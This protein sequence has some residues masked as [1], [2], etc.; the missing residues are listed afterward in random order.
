MTLVFDMYQN[1][2]EDTIS[3]VKKLFLEDGV[4][5]QVL[6]GLKQ[7]WQAK[8]SASKA[9]DDDKKQ[10]ES[11]QVEIK[12]V[13]IQIAVPPQTANGRILTVYVPKTSL[14]GD[15]LHKVLTPS[16]IHAVASLSQAVA[17]TVLQEHVNSA[18]STL[19]NDAEAD[20]NVMQFDGNDSDDEEAENES[21]N[22]DDDLTDEDASE[23]LQTDNVIVCQFDKID[24]N[25]NKW[26]L[27]LN[28]GIMNINKTDFIFQK[29]TGEAK[30]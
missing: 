10:I 9:V 26:K 15:Q 19:V 6:Q 29:A 14:K 8:V 5:E 16:L 11:A 30:W 28:K 13:P 3:G 24:R 7:N 23:V 21:L 20:S 22:S 4:D 17:N 18:L 25:R 1:V 27:H 12:M 2:I